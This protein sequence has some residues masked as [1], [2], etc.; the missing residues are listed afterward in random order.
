MLQS[1]ANPQS[2]LFREDG[3]IPAAACIVIIMQI[4]SEDASAIWWTEDTFLS[5]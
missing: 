5:I 2:A 3:K 4:V 1:L